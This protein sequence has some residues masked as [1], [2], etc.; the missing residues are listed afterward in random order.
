MPISNQ[1]LQICGE[2]GGNEELVFS[3]LPDAQY[4]SRP[5]KNWIKSS[6]ITKDLSFHGFRHTYATLQINNGTDIFTLSKMLG[7]KSVK[8]TLVYSHI[9]DEKK[10]KAAKVIELQSLK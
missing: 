6:G 4:I 2:R 5:L 9:L 1:A 3:G 10:N 7:H 8:T